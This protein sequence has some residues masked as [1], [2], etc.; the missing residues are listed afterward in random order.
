MKTNKE[1][2]TEITMLK[3]KI[4]TIEEENVELKK[5]FEINDAIVGLDNNESWE[6]VIKLIKSFIMLVD[7]WKY[8]F[9]DKTNFEI[10]L[11][12]WILFGYNDD[13]EWDEFAYFN[14]WDWDMTIWK[15]EMIDH[16]TLVYVLEKILN[17]VN[18]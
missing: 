4:K 10:E 5:V 18:I 8:S 13:T 11:D 1:L 2:Q 17:N 16:N 6:L 12:K 14:F 7:K 9:R 3:R 15:D